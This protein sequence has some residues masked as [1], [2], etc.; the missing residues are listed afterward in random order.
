MKLRSNNAASFGNAAVATLLWMTDCWRVMPGQG[1]GYGFSVL[2]E[3]ELS[4]YGVNRGEF[5]EWIAGDILLERS[6][7]R[8]HGAAAD[9]DQ[10]FRCLVAGGEVQVPGSCECN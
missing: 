9:T 4:P 8:H 1:W 10:S 2:M 5:G 7:D 6:A 3:P